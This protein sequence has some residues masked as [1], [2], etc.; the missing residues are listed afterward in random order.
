MRAGASERTVQ[1]LIPREFYKASAREISITNG[2][3]IPS[4]D[5]VYRKIYL[6]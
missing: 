1:E 3:N 4:N 6:L 2:T 5:F